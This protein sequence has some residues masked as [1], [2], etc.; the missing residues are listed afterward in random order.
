MET[1]GEIEEEGRQAFK[2]GK[3]GY[4]CPYRFAET[5]F[6]DKKDY[7]GFARVRWKLDARMRGWLLEKAKK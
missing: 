7:D 6:W 1:P 2:D 5:E 3:G 4:E